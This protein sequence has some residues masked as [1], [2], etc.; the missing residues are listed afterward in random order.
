[1][2]RMHFWIALEEEVA[3]AEI[4]GRSIIIQLDAN[5]KLGKGYIKKDPKDISGN[6]KVLAGILERHALIVVNGMEEICSGTITRE[7]HTTEHVEQSVI[8][9]IIIS[10]DLVK[11][12]ESM[13]I[14]E[15]RINVLSKIMKKK[16]KGGIE[17]KESD[18]NTINAV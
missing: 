12:V 17:I 16:H 13:N 1:M 5:A 18:H 6:G 14:D 4:N 9:F 8:D 15:A 3:A 11:H 7:R 10:S 2:K